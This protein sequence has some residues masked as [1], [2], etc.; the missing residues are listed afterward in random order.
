MKERKNW[1]LIAEKYGKELE[2]LRHQLEEAEIKAKFY[3]IVLASKGAVPIG[4]IASRYG[5]S[6]KGLHKLLEEHKILYYKD[7]AWWL[8]ARYAKKGYYA[9]KTAVFTNDE[10][11]PFVKFSG[12]WTP[13]GQAFLHDFLQGLG[14]SPAD[15]DSEVIDNDKA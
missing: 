13:K 12:V 5:L 3:D 4:R 15:N 2:E 11:E 14:Y 8:Y 1:K 9:E 6:A 10:G 7:G